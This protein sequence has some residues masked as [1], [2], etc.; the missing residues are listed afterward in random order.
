MTFE[1]SDISIDIKIRSFLSPSAH[2]IRNI[3]NIPPSKKNKQKTEPFS[4]RDP[5]RE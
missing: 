4:H 5:A 2:P 1:I 3:R